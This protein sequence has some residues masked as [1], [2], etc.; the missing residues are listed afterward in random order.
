MD[1]DTMT[2]TPEMKEGYVISGDIVLF[3]GQKVKLVDTES[4]E[5]LTQNYYAK[6]KSKVFYKDQVI[7]GAKPASLQII[8]H[9]YVQDDTNVFFQGKLEGMRADVAEQKAEIP[10]DPMSEPTST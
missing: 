2:D 3:N 5:I 8:D 4:F 9:D 7:F 10:E 6:D 1:T